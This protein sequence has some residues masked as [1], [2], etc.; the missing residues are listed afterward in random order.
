MTETRTLKEIMAEKGLLFGWLQ[1]QIGRSRASVFQYRKNPE[2]TP[3]LVKK[4]ICR[5]LDI[6]GW[7]EEN[8]GL[9][10][11]CSKE[12]RFVDHGD[13]SICGFCGNDLP[14]DLGD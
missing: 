3:P 9:K 4:E 14:E 8:L 5:I 1:K 12:K 7:V 6:D 2:S 11:K 10:C 13:A